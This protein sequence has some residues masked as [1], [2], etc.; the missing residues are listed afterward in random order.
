LKIKFHI[1]C[2][3]KFFALVNCYAVYFGSPL[4]T[5]WGKLSAPS[6]RGPKD[7]LTTS[8][9]NKQLKLRKIP[10]EQRPHLN[11][12]IS[13]KYHVC[14]IHCRANRSEALVPFFNPDISVYT[15]YLV[16]QRPIQNSACFIRC[17][18]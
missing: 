16:C 9:S 5:F 6:S 4:P 12:G 13:L 10:E 3:D 18:N 2:D 11:R 1:I 15:H 17:P 7:C 8:A 14:C